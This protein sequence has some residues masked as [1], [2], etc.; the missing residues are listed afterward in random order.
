[1]GHRQKKGRGVKSLKKE[2]KKP[3]EEIL[4]DD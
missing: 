4:R 3:K 1:M 2:E